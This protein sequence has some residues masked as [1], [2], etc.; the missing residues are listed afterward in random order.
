MRKL[1]LLGLILILQGVA[2]AQIAD[3]TEKPA[4]KE[5]QFPPHK[6]SNI[7]LERARPDKVGNIRPQPGSALAPGSKASLI[8]SQVFGA[9]FIA[10]G[11]VLF[12]VMH[13]QI[14]K[15]KEQKKLYGSKGGGLAEIGRGLGVTMA[16][17]AVGGGTVMLILSTKKLQKLKASGVTLHASPGNAGIVYTF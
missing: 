15:A 17:A 7:R 11:A 4:R 3:S 16:N 13:H 5:R 2:Y 1:I 8:G 6:R 10:S 14:K 9:A 12:P